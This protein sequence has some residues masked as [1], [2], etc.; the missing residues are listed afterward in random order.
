MATSLWGLPMSNPTSNLET[1]WSTI[2]WRSLDRLHHAI[3]EYASI[4]FEESSPTTNAR[5]ASIW[6]NLNEAQK[7]AALKLKAYSSGEHSAPKTKPE[8]VC[9]YPCA[10]HLGV[11]WTMTVGWSPL[12]KSVCPICHPPSRAETSAPRAG[13]IY[14]PREGTEAC[15]ICGFHKREH[16][17]EY[18]PAENGEGDGT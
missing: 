9:Y 12:I 13:H 14:S 5:H 11:P 6:L 4:G 16:A 17:P 15:F 18:M 10:Q 2:L 8:L 3:K 7:D 1:R